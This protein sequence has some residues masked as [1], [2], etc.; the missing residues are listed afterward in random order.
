MWRRVAFGEDPHSSSGI[1]RAIS[2]QLGYI[3]MLRARMF[4]S[5]IP[6]LMIKERN[7]RARNNGCP[8]RPLSYIIPWRSGSHTRFSNQGRVYF[9]SVS[10]P[11]KHLVTST[12]ILLPREYFKNVL[13]RWIFSWLR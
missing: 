9:R 8:L 12:S 6:V 10:D 5:L 11:L 13:K 2:E 4:R 7:I 3:V 1:P